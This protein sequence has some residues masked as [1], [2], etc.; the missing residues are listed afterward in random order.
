[1]SFLIEVKARENSESP[2]LDGAAVHRCEKALF[3][4]PALAASGTREKNTFSRPVLPFQ[5]A[6]VFNMK[7]NLRS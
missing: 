3:P 1:V 7:C 2:L 6:E 5:L 4:T